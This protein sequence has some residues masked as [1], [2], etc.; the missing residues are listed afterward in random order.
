MKRTEILVFLCYFIFQ[1]YFY[2]EQPEN[3]V[4]R[5]VVMKIVFASKDMNVL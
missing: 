3:L 5:G 2:K 4:I 1:T